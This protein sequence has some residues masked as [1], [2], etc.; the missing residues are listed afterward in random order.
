MLAP[1]TTTLS[2]CSTFADVFI[3]I[4]MLKTSAITAAMACDQPRA[5]GFSPRA[6]II[7]P[8]MLRPRSHR[9]EA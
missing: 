8:G 4:V 2:M 7:V 3:A 6:T 5:V 9:D 1:K